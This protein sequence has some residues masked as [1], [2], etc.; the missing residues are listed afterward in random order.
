MPN[1]RQLEYL[2]AV[3][4]TRNFRRAA[5]RCETTQPTL[6]EQLKALENRLG[7]TLIERTRTRVVPTP[8]GAQIVDIARRMLA[9]ARE[10]EALASSGGSELTGVLRLGLP[11][12]I[13][14]YLL[15]TVIPELHRAFPALKLYVREELP[16]ELPSA[17]AEG[18]HDLVLTLLPVKGSQLV[19]VPLFREP[20]LLSVAG[21][22]PLAEHKTVRRTHLVGQDILTLGKGHQ[23]HDA[24]NAFCDGLDA[25]LRLDYEGTSLDTLREMVAMGL[26]VTFLPGLYVH[27][28]AGRDASI[29]ILRLE[30]RALYRAAGLVWRRSSPH[31]D[32]Y[33]AM[34]DLLRDQVRQNFPDLQAL[35]AG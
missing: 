11:P 35:T 2:V 29:R 3:A 21:D 7:V 4:D 8:L 16:S 23:L 26:G 15:P 33:R 10:I 12:T 1:L 27:A 18:R 20:L 19:S 34:A 31:Q 25:R 6:S 22:H 5:E 14:P 30:D 13:G 24:V 28:V 17:L 32:C 9:D